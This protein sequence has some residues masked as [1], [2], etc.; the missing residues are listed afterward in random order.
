[1][2]LDTPAA[3]LG[4]QAE[5]FTL[6]DATGTL[7]SLDQLF[8]LDPTAAE[9]EP[10]KALLVAFICNHCP[11]VKAIINQLVSDSH[12]LHNDGI[13][14]VAIN[15][16]DFHYVTADSPEKMLEFSEKHQLN[17]PYLVDEQQ[18]V[19]KAYGAVCTPDFFGFNADR[20]LQYRGRLDN[21][22]FGGNDK[23]IAELVN[24]MQQIAATGK[25]PDEQ[26]PSIGCSIKWKR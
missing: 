5:K 26:M 19:A 6:P 16:N 24:A 2:L 3:T 25:G 22:G 14:F 4:W 9:Q 12:L 8:T 13:R 18:I 20:Q 15:P 17:F 11:Y 21:N 23:R 10:A 7:F 1:M